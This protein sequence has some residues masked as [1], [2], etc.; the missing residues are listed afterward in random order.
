LDGPAAGIGDY[1]IHGHVI[2]P[3]GFQLF[4]VGIAVGLNAVDGRMLF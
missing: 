3:G 2:G 1:K 4:L